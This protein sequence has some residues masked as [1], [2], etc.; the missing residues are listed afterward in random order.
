MSK[1]LDYWLCYFLVQCLTGYGTLWRRITEMW[2]RWTGKPLTLVHFT[3][4]LLTYD[5][6]RSD[7][8]F[9]ILCLI[10]FDQCR[11]SSTVCV[12]VFRDWRSIILTC[13]MMRSSEIRWT[14]TPSSSPVWMRSRS[15][16]LNRYIGPFEILLL[17]FFFNQILSFTFY[18][19]TGI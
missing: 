16:L 17:N 6:R 8:S 11:L 3:C 13:L 4:P 19:R 14:C 9:M 7:L 18:C 5:L 12:C 15:L 2:C 1:Y 10:F